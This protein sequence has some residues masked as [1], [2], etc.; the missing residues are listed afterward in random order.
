VSD[1]PRFV[2]GQQ[3]KVREG[4]VLYP[5]TVVGVG[6][7]GLVR[8]DVD[9]ASKAYMRSGRKSFPTEDVV[10][11]DEMMCIVTSADGRSHR[12]DRTDHPSHHVLAR[13][14]PRSG[15]YV[16][17]CDSGWQ[18]C[19]SSSILPD[20]DLVDFLNRGPRG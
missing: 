14:H 10:D 1:A 19:D 6:R 5:G 3:V 9:R 11:L 20:Q 15:R 8:V 18:L 13:V 7:T 16:T 12:I 4:Y 2:V 17:P